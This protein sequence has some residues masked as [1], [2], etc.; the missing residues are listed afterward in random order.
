MNIRQTLRNN[1]SA[2][3]D[4]GL[5][6]LLALATGSTKAQA[7]LAGVGQAVATKLLGPLGLMAGLAFGATKSLI[8]MTRAWGGMGLAGAA[9]LE[10]VQNQLRV[11]L[12]G[13]DAAKQR[14]RVL[15]DFAVESPFK[16]NDIVQGDRSLQSLTKGALATKDAMSMI[17]D[18]AAQAGS[19]FGT[20][21]EHV[22]KLYD[23]LQAGRPIGDVLFRL[24]DLGV[25]SGTARNQIEALQESGAGFNE[26][27]RVVEGQLRRSAGTMNYTSRTLE[28]LQST[29]EDTEDQMKATFSA[30]FIEGQKAAVAANIET[31]Q[32]LMPAVDGL[33]R[34]YGALVTVTTVWTAQ[35]AAFVTRLPGASAALEFLGR[36]AGVTAAAISALS[37][38]IGGSS[39]VGLLSRMVGGAGLL[40]RAL[41]LL[42][43]PLALLRRG[44]LLLLG[45]MGLMVGVIAILGTAWSMYRDR[46]AQTAEAIREYNGATDAMVAKT[47]GQIRAVKTLDN[48]AQVYTATLAQLTQAYRDEAAARAEGKDVEP[49]RR[50]IEAQRR[51]LETLNKINRAGLQAPPAVVEAQSG[52]MAQARGLEAQGRELQREFM[53]PEG[54]VRSLEAEADRLQKQRAAADTSL[55]TEEGFQR[56]K[57]DLGVRLQANG[58]ARAEAESDLARNK[59]DAQILKNDPKTAE[60]YRLAMEA[61][62]AAGAKIRELRKEEKALALEEVALSQASSDRIVQLQ[63]GLSIV[64]RYESAVEAMVEAQ[65]KLAEIEAGPETKTKA[66]EMEE[67]RAVLEEQKAAVDALVAAY[68]KLGWDARKAQEAAAELEIRKKE[69]AEDAVNSPEE[70]QRRAEAL[71]EKQALEISRGGSEIDAKARMEELDRG[72][73]AGALAQIQAEQERLNLQRQYNQIDE[74]IYQ[75]RKQVLE[76]EAEVL[77]AKQAE[78]RGVTRA[79]AGA[80]EMDLRAKALRMR[81]KVKEARDLEEAAQRR[82]EDAGLAGRVRELKDEGF[83]EEEAKRLAQDEIKRAR[84]GRA[85]DRITADFQ[86][87]MGVKPVVDSLQRIGGGGLV[88][89]QGPR[90]DVQKV[91]TRM[92]KI[93]AA[94]ERGNAGGVARL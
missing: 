60:G 20:M 91:I 29:L 26:V 74:E 47:E 63:G 2:L 87:Q 53:T 3:V 86:S 90:T 54:R 30:S 44:L 56:K 1:S 32:N 45:P 92:D 42:A 67:A 34:G 28:G 24:Q 69:R 16:L 9:R 38:A 51:V 72:A 64:S 5:A 77:K 23:G 17:G 50:R 6:G 14:V 94:I 49:A 41:V 12:K 39:L 27:W 21:A 57:N 62:A 19:D 48:L 88:A 36:M 59:L 85:V 10:T 68:K 55:N 7:A 15:R 43:G 52:R 83:D 33:G 71:R 81:G 13:L 66:A 78:A 82:K 4:G 84:A 80:D 40:G 93:L 46:M 11:L 61:A 70:Q 18:A 65:R 25:I 22:G 8:A 75:R 76:R 89:G 58:A 79:G 35:L 37:V 73:A 31:L